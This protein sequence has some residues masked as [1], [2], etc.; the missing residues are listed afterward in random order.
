M[1]ATVGD[2]FPTFL[3]DLD[4]QHAN[5]AA[6]VV[7]VSALQKL[8]LFGD[9]ILAASTNENHISWLFPIAVQIP[10]S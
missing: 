7:R 4:F 6:S 1:L 10:F 5:D 2:Y 3:I 9:C 8:N